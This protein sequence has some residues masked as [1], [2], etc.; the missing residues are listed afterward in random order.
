MSERCRYLFV[1]LNV[2]RTNLDL[3][4]EMSVF[5][6]FIR[7]EAVSALYFNTFPFQSNSNAIATTIAEFPA[8]PESQAAI[9]YR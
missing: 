8:A 6:P 5:V 9:W 1:K 2:G 7:L 4:P 3:Q